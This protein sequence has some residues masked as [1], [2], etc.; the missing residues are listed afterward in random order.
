MDFMLDFFCVHPHPHDRFMIFFKEQ[1][2]W[3]RLL[4]QV[5]CSPQM[6]EG[7]DF[8]EVHANIH[9]GVAWAN[10]KFCY[11]SSTPAIQGCCKAVILDVCQLRTSLVSGAS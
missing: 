7:E 9:R 4:A 11:L 2:L 3:S 8:K 10:L 5:M 1:F 6:H